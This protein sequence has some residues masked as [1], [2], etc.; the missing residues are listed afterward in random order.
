MSFNSF[1][2]KRATLILF[3]LIVILSA[4][5]RVTN[6]NLIEFKDD[7]A[8]NLFL[9]TRAMFGHAIPPASTVS[10]LGVLNAPLLNYLILPIAVWSTDPRFISFF[11]GLLNSL[12]IGFFFITLRKYYGTIATFM[13]S[14]MMSFSPWSILYSRKIWAQDF[15]LMFMILF[16]FLV[17]KYLFEDKTKYVYFCILLLF[18]MVQ[19]YQP[20]V[21]FVL[22]V[23]PFLFVK[24]GRLEI[25]K[26]ITFIAIGILPLIPYMIY[27]FTNKCPDCSTLFSAKN[28]LSNIYDLTIF[29]RPFQILNDGNMI[30]VIGKD[31]TKLTYSQLFSVMRKSYVVEYL[32]LIFGAIIFWK[33][34]KK[35]RFILYSSIIIPIIYFISHITPHMHY[36]IF[37]IAPLFLFVGI[38]ISFFVENKNL[39]LKIFGTIAFTSI[40]ASFIY[41]DFSF[42]KL[43]DSL[44]GFD[45]DFGRTFENVKKDRETTFGPYQKDKFYKEMI[46]ASYIPKYFIHSDQ[47]GGKMLYGTAID[48]KRVSLLDERLQKVPV[49]SIVINELIA[50]YTRK[51]VDKG[52]L[53][54][55]KKKEKDIPG[56]KYIYEDLYNSLPDSEKSTFND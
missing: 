27:Q 17:H 23:A 35:L 41:F 3:I 31:F 56:Y 48:A 43:L 4:A 33:K 53:K 14:I 44:R 21:F 47:P 20:S 50:F 29:K 11:I 18:L 37:L 16:M 6:L 26:V 30:F 42:F 12:A 15:L 24:H 38:G 52:T 10:S 40:T 5:Y 39:L 25:K 9:A 45:G 22:L 51:P 19:L 8:I 28:K 55:I 2:K 36:F 46:I 7:E 1:F 32:L 34:N 54:L 13:A 49:D